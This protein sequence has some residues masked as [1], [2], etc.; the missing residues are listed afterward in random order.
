MTDEGTTSEGGK[1]KGTGQGWMKDIQGA[2][3][4][5]GESV[6]T[7]WDATR[8]DRM[9]ALEAAKQ[10]AKELGEVLEK[11]MEAAR[12]RWDTETGAEGNEEEQPTGAAAGTSPSPE[13]PPFPGTDP[14]PGDS[15]SP[16]E[17][18]GG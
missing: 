17:P 18:V 7:A 4:R 11:G 15:S 1:E 5:T 10:A 16:D 9:R 13:P 3:D 12:E 6:R 8:E 2:L 14:Q